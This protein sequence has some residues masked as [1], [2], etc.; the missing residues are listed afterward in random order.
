MA[1]LNFATPRC[2]VKLFKSISR[3]VGDKGLNTSE[4]YQNRNESIELTDFLGEGGSVATS[5]S[6]DAPAGTFTLTFTDKATLT[7]DFLDVKTPPSYESVYG[8]VEPMDAV[9][10]R[11]WSGVG[12]APNPLPIKMRGIVTRIRRERSMGPDGKPRSV[13]VITGHDYGKFLQIYQLL[14]LSGYDGAEPLLTSHNF[15][16]QFG[17]DVP[18]SMSCA[19][20][21]TTL[22][23]KAINPMIESLFPDY[24]TM[25]HQITPDLQAT[26]MM[27]NMFQNEKG[28]VYD[29]AHTFMDVSHWNEFYVE[30]RED[31]VYLVWRPKPYFDIVS[32][33][34]IQPMVEPPYVCV[35]DNDWITSLAQERDD[36]DVH[37]FFYVS[38]QRWQMIDDRYQQ[39]VDAQNNYHQE[40]LH[41][42][43][44]DVNFYGLRPFAADS[45]T[46]PE[47]R[48]MSNMGTGQNQQTQDARTDAMTNWLLSRR[49]ICVDSNKNNVVFESGEI[50]M[51]GG[52]MSTDHIAGPGGKTRAA[53]PGDYFKIQEGNLH[54]Y[55]Y[56]INMTDTFTP[57]HS[58]TTSI[59]FVRGTGFA[60]RVSKAGGNSPY[61][62]EKTGA[63]K[64]QCF[65]SYNGAFGN[66]INN[67]R[68]P[69]NATKQ[70]K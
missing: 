11:M 40:Q 4:R 49:Q 21:V 52:P 68:F 18:N 9:E 36:E 7:G 65:P 35:L 6:L 32:G 14:Y 13:V 69:I 29:L 22:L 70:G 42:P 63:N 60:E 24:N 19:D 48:E 58:Y 26:G 33:D 67:D 20:F 8:L 10:I 66:V 41:Y 64:F 16:E 56:A 37:N 31:G 1:T 30:D 45:A 5:K 34:A 59:T 28:S 44:T 51:K 15:F 50:T 12:K 61:L 46:G 2:S 54:W 62:S 53:K 25:P 38:A 17:M 3:K 39:I 23:N 55:C 27:S 43:N 47:V 57:Y